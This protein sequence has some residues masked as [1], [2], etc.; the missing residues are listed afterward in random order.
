M[1]MASAMM[2]GK[3]TVSGPMT[4]AG[5]AMGPVP[6]RNAVVCLCLKGPVIAREIFLIRSESVRIT[7]RI[8]MQTD[9]MIPSVTLVSMVSH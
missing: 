7:S 3:M 8:R 6:S 5:Y 4:N 1:E 9:S 2:M